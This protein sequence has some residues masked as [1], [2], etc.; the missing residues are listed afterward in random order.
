MAVVERPCSRQSSGGPA[1]GAGIDPV[2]AECTQIQRIH[3]SVDRAHRIIVSDE[4]FEMR[5][6][7]PALI[8]RRAFHKPLYRPPPA[9]RQE[10]EL[11]RRFHTASA[12]Y[13]HM[14]CLGEWREG[15]GFRPFLVCGRLWLSY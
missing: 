10:T 11:L 1:G 4:V 13:C 7:Q 5:R 3:E 6:K 15:R 2:K 9:S 8:P 12:R 14:A